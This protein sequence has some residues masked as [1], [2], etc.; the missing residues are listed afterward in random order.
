M[1][2]EAWTRSW[3]HRPRHGVRLRR[4][5]VRWIVSVWRDFADAA[6]EPFRPRNWLPA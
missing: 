1:A 6:L 2:S 5:P 4:S 3:E